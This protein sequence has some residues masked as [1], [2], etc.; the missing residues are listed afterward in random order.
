MTT[1]ATIPERTVDLRV[2]DW[3]N[4]LNAM[5]EELVAAGAPNRNGAKFSARRAMLDAEHVQA[6]DMRRAERWG[7]ALHQR[8][9]AVLRD[10][11]AFTLAAAVGIAKRHLVDDAHYEAAAEGKRLGYTP[12]PGLTQRTPGR[13][14]AIAAVRSY[15]DWLEAHPDVP[16]PEKI[17]GACYQE[18][19]EVVERLAAEH[20][21]EVR[22]NHS[23]WVEIDVTGGRGGVP[24]Y[25]TVHVK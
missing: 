13:A 5:A 4:D 8:A 21:V 16:A 12:A 9:R 18:A 14:M 19:A 25:H 24:V 3:E 22:E 7:F 17:E 1:S 11:Q 20:G 2:A 15:A 10:G 6:L 23:R